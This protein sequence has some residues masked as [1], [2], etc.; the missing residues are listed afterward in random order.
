MTRCV[1]RSAARVAALVALGTATGGC[2]DFGG[3]DEPVE[4]STHVDD[5][6][7]QIIYQ[8]LV[9]R[10][11][12]GD[13]G[14]DFMVDRT[15][16]GRWH[17][18]DWAGVESQLDYL[19]GLGVTALWI[20]PLYKNVETD[21]GVDGY[22]GY[23]PQDFTAPNEHF[24][25]VVA[26]RRMVDAAH[27]HGILVIIDVV[28][29]H[30]GQLF[31]YDINL[32]G[33]PDE[34]VRGS[35]DKSPVVH[36]NEYDPDFDP[37]GIQAYTSLGEAG[38]AP[39]IFNWD[40]ASNHM[41][42]WPE[43]LQH[44]AAYNKRGRTLDFEDPDQLLHGDFPG[45][46]KDLDTTRCDVKDAMVDA[47]AR[48]VE[49]SDVDGFRIDTIKHV[50]REFWRYFAQK[51]RQ[52]LAA[53]GK[54]RFFMFGEAFDGRPELVGAYTQT[55]LPSAD[56]LER[57]NTCVHDGLALTGDQLDGVF[58]FPQ[59]YTVVRDV[60]QQGLSTDRIEGLW[61]ARSL[62]YGATP[63][64]LG[65]GIPPVK[66]LVNFLDN[67]DVPRFLFQSDRSALH[68]ALTFLLT[69]DGIPCVYYGTEQEL[70]GGNDPANREDLWET[71]YDT[72]K[73]TYQVIAR[74]AALRKAYLALRRGD[75]K[76]TWASNR[77]GD[78]PDAGIFA[79]ERAGGDAGGA[80]ALVVLN[81]NRDH[82]S[83]PVFGGVP[84]HVGAPGGTTL[85]DV[86]ATAQPQ[87]AYTVAADGAL[88]ITVPPLGQAILVP[89][90]DVVPGI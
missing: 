38:P 76:V 43:V 8:L 16:P 85:V 22:H 65:T 12:D 83:S 74:L 32:N 6:R 33:Q 28:T 59:Y 42:P 67:H 63:T 79:F 24:G 58:H 54:E 27:Q 45:G 25:D 57:E 44:A 1:T 2:M 82:P 7:D 10:F 81:T 46:L 23:W 34:Q 78:E 68:Q 53:Q 3:Y 51:V 30:V 61:S 14:N 80:Y 11:A 49:L 17:G 52:R 15:A 13:L 56:Q 9:D 72:T 89:A 84:M 35:G 26:L 18:G 69:E 64:Q 73:P 29:N 31:Y 19:S 75:Q 90:A 70:A 36:I 62:Y 88:T 39:V 47:Y 50:E 4:L 55:D 77:T 66:T 60:L 21:A 86:W 71:G 37:R 20:S 5:W 41:P 40:P 87:P 48:W